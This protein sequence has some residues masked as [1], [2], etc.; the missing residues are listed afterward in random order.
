[1]KNM[2]S[3]QLEDLNKNKIKKFIFLHAIYYA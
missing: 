2:K 1:M 3:I